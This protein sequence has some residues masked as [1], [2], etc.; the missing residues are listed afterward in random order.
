MNLLNRKVHI[1]T[2]LPLS[3]LCNFVI[4]YV[5]KFQ[6]SHK[7]IICNPEDI[8]RW[9]A[10]SYGKVKGHFHLYNVLISL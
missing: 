2:K 10:K 4:I 8:G 9:M 3:F 5:R 6:E 7:T 1:W